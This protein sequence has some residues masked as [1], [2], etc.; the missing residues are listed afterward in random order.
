MR[1]YTRLHYAHVQ[2]DIE[3]DR[4]KTRFFTDEDGFECV[5]FWTLNRLGQRYRVVDF[6]SVYLERRKRLL[7]S[8][9]KGRDASRVFKATKA[10]PLNWQTKK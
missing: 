6:A 1:V 9:R 10:A 2:S 7:E 5:A 8:A 3:R 4:R